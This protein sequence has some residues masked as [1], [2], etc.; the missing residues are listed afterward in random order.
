MWLP[1]VSSFCCCLVTNSCLTL[2]RPMDCSLPGSS[3]HGIS[4]ARILEWV[5][6]SFS[7]GSSQSKDQTCISCI[8]CWVTRKALYIHTYTHTHISVWVPCISRYNLYFQIKIE[9]ISFTP[10]TSS[11]PLSCQF[12]FP[13]VIPINPRGNCPEVT[14]SDLISGDFNHQRLVEGIFFFAFI[15]KIILLKY[16]WFIMLH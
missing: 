3:D 1:F 13:G 16:S 2:W 8:A 6:I 7:R 4:R 12:P 10:E 15:G 5:A 9:F 11:A 14:P